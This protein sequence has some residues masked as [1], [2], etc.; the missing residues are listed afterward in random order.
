MVI[1]SSAPAALALALS[2]RSFMASEAPNATIASRIVTSSPTVR[3]H[4]FMSNA[5]RFTVTDASARQTEA[6]LAVA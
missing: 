2:D 4:A 1:V 3:D 6:S 5:E